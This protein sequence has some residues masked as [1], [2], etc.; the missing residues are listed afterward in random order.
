MLV[1][2]INALDM[3]WKILKIISVVMLPENIIRKVDTVNRNIPEVKIFFL[4]MMSASRPNGKRKIAEERRKLLITQPRLIALACSSLPIEGRARLSAD[5]RKG[6]RNAAKVE[7][8]STAFLKVFSSCISVFI[9]IL[10]P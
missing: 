10:F 2:K 5:V 6:T 9:F 7:T 8:R 4:P 3:P 1:P